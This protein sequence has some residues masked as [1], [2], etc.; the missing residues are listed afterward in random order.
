MKVSYLIA[1][2]NS[3]KLIIIDCLNRAVETLIIAFY[4]SRIKIN[5]RREFL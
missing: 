4:T 3:I 5:K 2:D 1:L